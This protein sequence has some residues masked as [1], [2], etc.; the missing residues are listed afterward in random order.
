MGVKNFK[1]LL[2]SIPK[3]IEINS[4]SKSKFKSKLIL[5]WV[6]IRGQTQ[7]ILFFGVK[8]VLVIIIY[9]YRNEVKK[10]SIKHKK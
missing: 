4:E 6:P 5:V 2:I 3:C 8:C 10:N 9:L 1:R 7:Y